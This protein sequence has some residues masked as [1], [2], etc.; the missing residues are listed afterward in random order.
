MSLNIRKSIWFRRDE[1]G[2]I[3]INEIFNA[4]NAAYP[5]RWKAHFANPQAITDWRVIWAAALEREKV[6][7]AQ[8]MHALGLCAAKYAWPPSSAEFIALCQSQPAPQ[9]ERLPAKMTPEQRAK[10]LARFRADCAKI[11]GEERT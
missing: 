8:A 3:P 2:A 5:I 10:A 7:V 6:T 4:L 1:K 9:H 11:F